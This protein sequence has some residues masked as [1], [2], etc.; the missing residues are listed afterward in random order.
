MIDEEG[1]KVV[2]ITG[3]SDGLGKALAES[4]KDE[5]RVVILS[6]NE[7]KLKKVA[8]ELGVDFAVADISKYGE[9]EKAIQTIITKY[10]KIDYLVNNA[11]VWISGYLEE[12]NS[13]EIQRVIDTNV[14]GTMFVT[15]AVLPFMKEQKDGKIIN[16]I[17]QNGLSAKIDRSIYTA[18]KWAL[19]GFTKCLQMD[20]VH[21]GIAV[22]GFY[23]GLMKTNLFTGSSRDVS[24][25]M[26][27]KE[28]AENLRF[29]ISAPKNIIISEL[30][31]NPL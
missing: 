7:E 3:G 14:L 16:V 22:S 20:L 31:V 27:P 11:G 8:G 29:I 28:V 26:D 6:H 30:G 4:I 17:S 5:Y 19:T 24:H 9:V 25:S 18:S 15:R 2:L 10:K 1:K 23:P 13:T 12:V 21:S